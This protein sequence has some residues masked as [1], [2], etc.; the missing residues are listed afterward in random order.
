MA[1][2]KTVKY[3]VTAE[4]QGFVK[5]ME[6]VAAAAVAAGETIKAAFGGVGA[7]FKLVLDHI[8]AIAAVLAGGA[9][10]GSSIEETKKLAGEATQLSKSLGI[11]TGEAS[12]LN[13]A[14]RSIGSSADVYTDANEKLVRQVRKNEEGVRAMGVATRDSNGRLL[15]GQQLMNS[16]L[17]TLASYAEGTDR[18]AAGQ[19]LFG[20]GAAEVRALLKLNNE[21][22]DEARRKAEALGL[23]IGPQ[24]AASVKVYKESMEDVRLVI[25]AIENATGQALIPVLT[26]AARWFSSAG[27][28]AV[29]VTREAMSALVDVIGIVIDVARSLWT[30]V[31]E[32]FTAIAGTVTETTGVEIPGG[33]QI[34]KNAMDIVRLAAL[35][36]KAGIDVVFEFVRAQVL[37]LA[38][39][40]RTF[41]AVAV[42]AFHLDWEGVKDAWR[43][44]TAQTEA[45]IAESQAR[46]LKKTAENRAAMIAILNG[47]QAPKG[48]VGPPEPPKSSG[49]RAFVDTSKSGGDLAKAKFAEMRA[50]LESELALQREYLKE[51]EQI[52][53]DAYRHNR[54]TVEEFFAAKLAIEQ[55]DLRAALQ[56]K[57][58]ELTETVSLEGQKNLKEA[59]KIQLHAQELRIKGQLAVLNAQLAN[60][61]IK[62]AREL[63][64]ELQ[65]KQFR[66]LEIQR[67]AQ[68]D[69]GR[70]Q[71]AMDRV[72]LEQRRALRQVSDAQYLQDE[73]A[74]Q[75]R[76]FEVERQ[77]LRERFAQTDG[78]VEEQR[79][80]NAAIEALERQHAVQMASID[81]DILVEQHKFLLDAQ[82]SIENA[83]VQFLSD[84]GDRSKSLK[85]KLV[86]F[87]SDIERTFQ[88]LIAKQFA[89]QLFGSLMPGEGGGAGWLG[90]LFSNIFGNIPSF[91][92]GTP[93]VPHDT[94]AVVHRGERII[95]AADNAAGNFGGGGQTVH[96]SNNFT[97]NGPVDGRTQL[98]I[99][100]AA[101]R[102]VRTALARS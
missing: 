24:Q 65:K 6:E 38:S 60:S 96:V 67:L 11:A 9:A 53:A 73:K 52:Y 5:A 18:N 44:G 78:S 71:V 15:D 10:F 43:N 99:A 56:I 23:V 12:V 1:N 47:E 97:I 55:Q 50:E 54:I 51:A 13:V 94:L 46:V 66:L 89:K 90:S 31:R 68:L 17:K 86:S 34:W 21:V 82:S 20:K 14:L 30:A 8:G 29:S 76:L 84:L 91:D 79:K 92:V 22:M 98:Q 32:V 4:N 88:Q 83:S 87:A 62:N 77:A 59:E 7:A 85:D 35:A 26:E 95:T 63:N 72:Q 39:D 37:V 74:L 81:K 49:G 75:Q 16:A 28:V 101:G 45:I 27:P 102:G 93:F 40:L 100:A 80:I 19:A 61:E 70:S 25:S 2:D 58:Q 33:L 42:A 36:L 48:F 57:Q 69:I 64:D 3:D 41:A